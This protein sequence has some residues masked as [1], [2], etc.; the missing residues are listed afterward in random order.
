M[1]LTVGRTTSIQRRTL[2]SSSIVKNP[3]EPAWGC[4]GTR[5]RTPDLDVRDQGR[6]RQSLQHAR[7]R[8][9]IERPLARSILGGCRTIS[10][11]TSNELRRGGA[12]SD[13]EL[14]GTR[15]RTQT[16]SGSPTLGS[17]TLR[18]WHDG[19]SWVPQDRRRRR[20]PHTLQMLGHLRS[21]RRRSCSDGSGCRREDRRSLET[22]PSPCPPAGRPRRRAWR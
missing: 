11:R 19:M 15:H 18:R 3:G 6:H 22:P 10:E 17:T 2:R 1:R 14:H 9:R 21:A 12:W 4:A 20:G 13:R 16:R 8:L 7:N 5:G